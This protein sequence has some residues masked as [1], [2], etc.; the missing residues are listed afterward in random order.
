MRYRNQG[1]IH[2]AVTLLSMLTGSVG[3]PGAGCVPHGH[4]LSYGDEAEANLV[5]LREEGFEIFELPA[6]E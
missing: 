3:K 4:E 6:F 5:E 1:E 2:R